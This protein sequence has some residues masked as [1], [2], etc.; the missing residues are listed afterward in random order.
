VFC[1]AIKTNNR[2]ISSQVT[3]AASAEKGAT[4]SELQ[5]HDCMTSEQISWLVCSVSFIPANK[6]SLQE[7][8]QLIE[9]NL[10]TSDFL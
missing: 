5:A 3:Q 9:I 7:L 6:A 10:L 2:T 8:H 1:Y 4:M